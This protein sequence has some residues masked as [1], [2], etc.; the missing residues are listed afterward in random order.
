MGD[1]NP[2]YFP[3]ATP[4]SS[5]RLLQRKFQ[6]FKNLSA[7]SLSA[8]FLL[9]LPEAVTIDFVGWQ[10]SSRGQEMPRFALLG[11]SA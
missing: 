2:P 5:F 11:G 6:A 3:G 1:R 10:V 9:L 4:F 7:H 8:V